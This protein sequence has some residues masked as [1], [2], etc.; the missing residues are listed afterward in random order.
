MCDRVGLHAQGWAHHVFGLRKRQIGPAHMQ[1]VSETE[2][3][4]PSPVVFGLGKGDGWAQSRFGLRKGCGRAQ[5]PMDLGEKWAQPPHIGSLASDPVLAKECPENGDGWVQH[6]HPSLSTAHALSTHSKTKHITH[7]VCARGTAADGLRAL[8]TRDSDDVPM[9][10]LPSTSDILFPDKPIAL[11]MCYWARI[12]SLVRSGLRLVAVAEAGANLMYGLAQ[13]ILI[14]RGRTDP[15]HTNSIS[16]VHA[17]PEGP[18][19]PSKQVPEEPSWLFWTQS[20]RL[21]WTEYKFSVRIRLKLDCMAAGVKKEPMSSVSGK[22][23]CIAFG[24]H[25]GLGIVGLEHKRAVLDSK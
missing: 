17:Y 22:Q 20:Q 12:V 6:T 14:R 1:M 16:P 15:A 7:I 18:N 25:E 19:R 8:P 2:T 3:D 21:F 24:S 11:A 23:A 5:L 10:C 4:G 9:I 13:G